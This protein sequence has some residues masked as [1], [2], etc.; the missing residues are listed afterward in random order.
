MGILIKFMKT[1]KGSL[2]YFLIIKQR[3]KNEEYNKSYNDYVFYC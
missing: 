2:N 1:K 3:N